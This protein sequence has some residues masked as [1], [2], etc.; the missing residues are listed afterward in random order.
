MNI[1]STPAHD[2]L[3]TSPLP[4]A[5]EGEKG[6]FDVLRAH[7]AALSPAREKADGA[8]GGAEAAPEG[9]AE[10]R[11]AAADLIS[12]S[13][14]KPILAQLRAGNTAAAPFGPGLW[15]KQFAPMIDAAMSDRLVKSSS[16]DI[17]DAVARRL[18][19]QGG[20]G[21]ASGGSDDSAQQR[22]ARP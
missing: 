12:V 3:L 18:L 4:G 15:E 2:A 6:F 20:A 5:G 14:V 13:L 21:D 8:E 16:W 17:V 9:L 10:A 19:K 11:E 1:A 22:S 7:E